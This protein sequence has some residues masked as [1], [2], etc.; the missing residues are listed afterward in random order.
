MFL[1]FIAVIGGAV[2]WVYA[3]LLPAAL[4][5]GWAGQWRLRSLLRRQI[6]R[7]NERQGLLV[8]SIRG[9]ESIR[10]SNAGWRFAREWQEITASIDRYA[11]EQR[12]ISSLCSVTTGSLATVAYVSG[13]VV[14]VWQIEAGLLTMG[15]L[16]ACSILGG[17]IIAPVA[18][19]VQYLVQWQHVREALTLVQQVLTL[20]PDRR[21]GQTLL[22]PDE[23]PAALT[24]EG[25]RFAY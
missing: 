24:L 15:G 3:L 11:I 23:A 16:I 12:A 19:S 20:E 4:L 6:A 17:R 5:L 8:D 13:V 7:T 18:Q 14:G 1:V 9:A 21:P 10:A 22:V 2:A 25:V